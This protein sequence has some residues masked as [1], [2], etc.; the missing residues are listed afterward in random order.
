[1]RENTMKLCVDTAMLVLDD[2]TMNI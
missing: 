1:M 2:A